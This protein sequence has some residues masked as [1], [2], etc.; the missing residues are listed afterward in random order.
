[1]AE[2]TLPA[3][4]AGAD[5]LTGTGVFDELMKASAAHITAEYKAGRI[6][7]SDYATVYLGGLQAV[8]AQ[9]V[10]FLLTRQQAD[11]QA[12]LLAQQALTEQ[13]QQALLTQQTANAVTENTV[14]VAQ[15]CKLDAEFDLIMEQKLKTIAETALLNQ[16]KVTEQA[17]T[18]GTGVGVNSVI[19]KQTLLYQRQADGYLR[20][21][22]QKAAK[23]MADTWSVRM[24]NDPGT[25]YD[26]VNH[27][28][29]ADVGRAISSMLTGINA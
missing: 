5:T 14:L 28:S 12:E 23:M 1:M 6:K 4:T 8:L 29:D 27:L 22:E 18:D 17:Q 20:D 9:S 7:G 11:K 13:Q 21:A 25:L 19:G 10:Q 26:A 15:E 24:T 3:L 16:K 2:I